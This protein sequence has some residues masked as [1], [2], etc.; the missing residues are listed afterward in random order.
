[1]YI[2]D[3]LQYSRSRHRY[4]KRQNWWLYI[5]FFKD[6]GSAGIPVADSDHRPRELYHLPTGQ[7]LHVL[8]GT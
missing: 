6:E 2:K 7:D 4:L 5:P 1:M 3:M 8:I